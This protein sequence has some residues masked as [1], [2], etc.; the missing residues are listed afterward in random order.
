MAPNP[1]GKMKEL[2]NAF[3]KA[4]EVQQGAQALQAE[5][6][7]LIIEGVSS[8]GL[9]KVLMS[10]NQEPRGVEI[11]DAAIAEGAEKVSAMVSEAMTDAFILS[12]LKQCESHEGVD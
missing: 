7:Q 1:F 6:E 4:Q 2:A 9:V 12:S 8:N 10:G 5:L 11:S 3:Q